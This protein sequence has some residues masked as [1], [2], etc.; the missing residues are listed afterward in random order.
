MGQ[1][2]AAPWQYEGWCHGRGAQPRQL[3]NLQGFVILF[4]KEKNVSTQRQQI[5]QIYKELITKSGC[6]SA[7]ITN[8]FSPSH[9]A[10]TV[11]R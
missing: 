6:G 9:E 1:D 10:V 4:D 7:T 5:F 8:R 3:W 11:S 2:Q